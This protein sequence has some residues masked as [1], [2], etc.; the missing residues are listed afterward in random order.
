MIAGGGRTGALWGTT[1][2]TFAEFVAGDKERAKVILEN[3]LDDNNYTIDELIEDLR[4]SP[5]SG[6]ELDQN[7]EDMIYILLYIIDP[8]KIT[9]YQ[10]ALFRKDRYSFED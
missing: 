9:P 3:F 1:F 5:F 10:K 2:L 7:T 8:Q 4:N 6:G